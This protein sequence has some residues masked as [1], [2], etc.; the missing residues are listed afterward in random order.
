MRFGALAAALI[1]CVSAMGAGCPNGLD[2]GMGLDSDY[3]LIPDGAYEGSISGIVQVWQAG[4]LYFEDSSGGESAATFAHG[5]VMK[6]SGRKLA[7]GDEEDVDTG[8]LQATRQVFDIQV[9]DLVYEVD[10]N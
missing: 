7:I 2:F 4:E 10:Y 6:D 8:A 3:Q 9:D 5:A 1:V